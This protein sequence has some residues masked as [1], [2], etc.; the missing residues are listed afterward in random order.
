L[1]GQKI[2]K[3]SIKRKGY[4]KW[5]KND[6]GKKLRGGEWGGNRSSHA[7]RKRKGGGEYEGK[8]NLKGEDPND[9]KSPIKGLASPA[10]ERPTRVGMGLKEEGDARKGA[11]AT[12][13]KGRMRPQK[14]ESISTRAPRGKERGA[15]PER[16]RKGHV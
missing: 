9:Q 6:P 15:H 11:R 14:G 16:G 10:R 7:G 12:E 1:S 5:K 8:K 4:D 2:L 3:T 13:N